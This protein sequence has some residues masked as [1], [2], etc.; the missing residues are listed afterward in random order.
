M[1]QLTGN[2]IGVL[3]GHFLLEEA[4]SG[5]ER[6]VVT[7]VVSSPQLGAIA[8]GMGVRYEETLTGFKWIAS[9]AMD[10]EPEGARFVFGY[11][12]ALGYTAGTAVRDKDGIGAALVAC[13]LAARCRAE[14]RDL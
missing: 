3:L 9:R 1:A 6:L 7:T 2:Q 8:R 14:G 12:E 13:E 10:V 11:E 5:P 4:G